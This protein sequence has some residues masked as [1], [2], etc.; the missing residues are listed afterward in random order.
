MTGAANAGT[1]LG[2]CRTLLEFFVGEVVVNFGFFFRQIGVFDLEKPQKKTMELT[3]EDWASEAWRQKSYPV[4][5]QT[6]TISLI[7]DKDFRHSNPTVH[8]R[9][10][11]FQKAFAPLM[12]SVADYFSQM[13]V[14]QENEQTHREGYFVRLIIVKLRDE[15]IVHPHGEEDF[16]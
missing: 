2:Y 14:A 6:Q 12:Q 1:Y 7:F 9:F 4:H 11:Q 13:P 8:S 10:E 5:Q 15:G 16:R 3:D